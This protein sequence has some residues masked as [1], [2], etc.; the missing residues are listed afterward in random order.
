MKITWIGHACFLIESEGRRI[1]TD[2]FAEEVPYDFPSVTAD[3]VTVS[4]D[5]HDHNA[6]HRVEGNPTVLETVG[7]H[8]ARGISLVGTTLRT[9]QGRDRQVPPSWLSHGSVAESFST[10]EPQLRPSRM[11]YF[12]C[13]GAAPE[14]VH[15]ATI[16]SSCLAGRMIISFTSTSAGSAIA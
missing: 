14:S 12:S 8:E 11:H 1:V 3:L 6:V 13:L 7:D 2:P 15:P 4:H 9:R 5:H 16:Q 10:K